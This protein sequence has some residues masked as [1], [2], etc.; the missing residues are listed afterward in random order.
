MINKKILKILFPTYFIIWKTSYSVWKPLLVTP[1]VP[2]P[3][4]RLRFSMEWIRTKSG[5]K[6]VTVPNRNWRFSFG[7]SSEPVE[8]P[9]F[10]SW[11]VCSFIVSHNY[12][13][14]DLIQKMH[15]IYPNH[16]DFINKS[17]NSLDVS[18]VV[19]Y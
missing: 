4:R 17:Y 1:V 19:L 11:N 9:I 12:F 10:F 5:Y 14:Y 7:S 6:M 16:F 2:G 18:K 8:S 15:Q 3:D 13:E